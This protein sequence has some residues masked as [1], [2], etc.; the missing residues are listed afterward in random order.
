MRQFAF[1]GRFDFGMYHFRAVVALFD[2]AK[3]THALP[4]GK[5][6]LLAGVEMDEAQV[7]QAA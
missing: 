7:E 4:F 3:R 6:L 1:F 5:L 2:F